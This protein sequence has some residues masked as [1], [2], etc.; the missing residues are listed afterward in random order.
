SE[1]GLSGSHRP[2]RRVRLR[3]LPH[4]G[5]N[6]ALFRFFLGVKMVRSNCSLVMLAGAVALTAAV[7]VNLSNAVPAKAPLGGQAPKES[8]Q[9]PPSQEAVL[10]KNTVARL[11]VPYG[12]DDK[13]RL[14][15]YSPKGVKDAPVVVF[16]HGGEWTRG[17][18]SAV[19]FKPKF[20]NENG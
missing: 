17:D 6:Q 4:P 14:D 20:L 15:V 5:L 19:S 1:S 8:P 18:K 9:K 2:T 12:K 16:V 3:H 7:A 10:A 11:D 13:Q